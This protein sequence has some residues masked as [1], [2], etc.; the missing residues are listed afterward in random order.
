LPEDAIAQAPV[1]P[2]DSARLLVCSS[3]GI[4]TNWVVR[5][6]PRILRPGDLLVFNRT[7]VRRARVMA[8]RPTGANVELLFLEPSDRDEPPVSWRVL[9]RPSRRL[10]ETETLT[11]ERRS[12]PSC[13]RVRLERYLGEGLWE[14]RIVAGEQEGPGGALKDA[15]PPHAGATFFAEHGEIPLPPYI[16]RKLLDSDRYQTVFGDIESSAAAPTAAL[17][18]TEELLRQLQLAGIRF[19][20]VHLAIGADTFRPLR[21]ETLAEVKMHSEYCEVGE[22]AAEEILAAKS[23][24]SRVVAVGTT[25]VRTLET[26]ASESGIRPGSW[27]TDLFI[28]PGF[29]FK[30][31][32]ALMTNFHAPGTSMLALLEAFYPGWRRAYSV[33]L[34]EGF[35]FLSFGDAML[36]VEPY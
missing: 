33:A 36:V 16:R 10:R 20:F 4:E 17:H 24:G 29:R 15:T 25:V 9:A 30:V 31:V 19:A 2:R 13:C 5:D 12:T 35:R 8:R 23:R 21:T 28:K 3:S 18:F 34:N 27:R 14:V 7:R 6:L 11:L 1:E 32:D 22:E 26:M